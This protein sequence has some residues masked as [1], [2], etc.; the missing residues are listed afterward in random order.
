MPE[1]GHPAHGGAP[2]VADGAPGAHVG[3]G[4]EAA[5]GHGAAPEVV[6]GARRDVAARTVVSS[7][8][9]RAAAGVLRRRDPS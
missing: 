4:S 9:P 3:C 5:P 1:R 8:T 7:T 2:E 6:D